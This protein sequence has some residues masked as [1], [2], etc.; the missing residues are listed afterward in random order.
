V[1]PEFLTLPLS[2]QADILRAASTSLNRGAMVLEKDVWVCWGLQQLF[3][4]PESKGMAFKGGTALSKVYQTI[5]RFSEDIDVT[6]DYRDIDPETP[7]LDE[8]RSSNQRSR[9]KERLQGLL[10][11]YVHEVVKPHFERAIAA[12]FPADDRVRLDVDASGEKFQIQYASA[13]DEGFGYLR[14]HV[15]IEFGGRNT[16]IPSADVLITADMA[17]VI[18]AVRFPE[19]TVRALAAERTFWEKAT[20]IH[21][22]NHKQALRPRYDRWSRHWYDLIR[23]ADHGIGAQALAQRELLESVVAHKKVFY[24]AADANY[25]A[26]VAGGLKLVTDRPELLE[27]LRADYDEMIASGMFYAETPGFDA[28]LERLVALEREIN[29]GSNV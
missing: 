21:A 28:I 26:C 16:T 8:V 12:Q 23:L 7:P 2:D 14:D 15:L 22:E 25:D 5:Q 9:L 3:S 24:Y 11:K 10:A 1:T 20:L 6:V 4:L 17:P 19:A 29:N 13:L 18:N 27:M